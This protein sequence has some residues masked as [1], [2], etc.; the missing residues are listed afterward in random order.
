MTKLD[1]PIKREI[2][3]DGK[4]HVVT[5]S[6]DGIKVVPKG[7]RIGQS[8]AWAQFGNAEPARKS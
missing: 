4:P 6:P 1:R 5:I 7:C 2:A 3:I 8:R